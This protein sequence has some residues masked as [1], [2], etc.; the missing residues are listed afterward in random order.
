MIHLS[1]TN[2]I[3]AGRFACL[4]E[5]QERFAYLHEVRKRFALSRE[6]QERFARLHEVFLKLRLRNDAVQNPLCGFCFCAASPLKLPL[7]RAANIAA[8]IRSS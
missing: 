8:L 1:K 7:P 2:T 4:R 5:V 3:D 6:V